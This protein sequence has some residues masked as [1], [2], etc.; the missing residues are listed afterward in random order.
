MTP[1]HTEIYR[2]RHDE[3]DAYGVLNNTAYLRLAQESAWRHS[4]AAGF[5][6]DYYEDL[7]RAWVARDSAI[8]YIKAVTYGDELAV[9][10]YV[11]S[12]GRSIARRSFNSV[13]SRPF[14]GETT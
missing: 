9:T 10:T 8:E 4:I 2:I 6:Y 7:E 12:S 14:K 13:G 1:R 5:G 11:P 3:C